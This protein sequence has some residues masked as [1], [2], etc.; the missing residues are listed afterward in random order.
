MLE[1]CWVLGYLLQLVQ[2]SPQGQG[3]DEE[4]EDQ[5]S[6]GVLVGGGR[7]WGWDK[8]DLLQSPGCGGAE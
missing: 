2:D 8:I 1:T 3:T 7:A 4:T 6:E 5:G